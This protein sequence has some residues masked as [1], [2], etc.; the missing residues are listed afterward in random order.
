MKEEITL[1]TISNII[2]TAFTGCNY[3]YI[4]SVSKEY[5][6]ARKELKDPCFED[7]IAL[8]IMKNKRI[9]IEIYGEK[10]ELTKSKLLNG[11]KIY[12][13]IDENNFD[14]IEADELIQYSLFGELVYG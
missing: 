7:V 2:T 9:T 3:K 6:K 13:K 12:G 8:L 4:S 14:Y 1:E 10:Y 5:K 11:L